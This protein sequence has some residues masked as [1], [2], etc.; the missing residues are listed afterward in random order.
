MGDRRVNVGFGEGRLVKSIER[1]VPR[2]E[3]MGNLYCSR[4]AKKLKGIVVKL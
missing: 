1:A 3:Y 4:I 2:A